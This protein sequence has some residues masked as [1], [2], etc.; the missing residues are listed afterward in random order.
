M[1][2]PSFDDAWYAGEVIDTRSFDWADSEE[3]RIRFDN[4]QVS[5]HDLA[6]ESY[7][8]LSHGA[9]E[10]VAPR[11]KLQRRWRPRRRSFPRASQ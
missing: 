2:E 9:G 3:V 4:G 10:S 8:W 1:R 5:W 11:T 7:E 6:G